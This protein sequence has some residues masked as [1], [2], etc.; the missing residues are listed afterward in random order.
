VAARAAHLDEDGRALTDNAER[1]YELARDPDLRFE[2]LWVA[3]LRSFED[4]EVEREALLFSRLSEAGSGSFEIDFRLTA[5]RGMRDFEFGRVD[6]AVAILERGFALLPHVS[7]PLVRTSFLNQL[8][9]AV[10]TNAR[11]ERAVD[12]AR[13]QREDA[14]ASGLEFAVDHALLGIARGLIGIR[15]LRLASQTLENLKRR[16]S[17]DAPYV[18]VSIAAAEAKLRLAAGDLP[19]AA[20]LLSS[21]GPSSAPAASRADLLALKALVTAALGDLQSAADLIAKAKGTS[22]YVDCAA[23]AGLAEAIIDLQRGAPHGLEAGAAAIRSAF[24]LGHVEAVVTASRAFPAIA[25]RRASESLNA[26]IREALTRSRDFDIA[27]RAGLPIPREL[28]RG[29]LLTAREQEILELL[30][31]GRSNREIGDALFISLATT[32]VHVKHIFE[33]LGV[34][35]RAEAAARFRETY[36]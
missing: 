31:S 1:A 3:W 36:D 33:K 28:R 10:Y 17:S 2:A 20:V 30:V 11:Y 8:S 13:A 34:H 15:K 6:D 35:S 18:Q 9:G 7:D 19:G 21:E 25:N 27:R 23:F 24:R 14:H 26:Q 16:A 4:Q 22:R 5:A 12:V 32:K 29:D